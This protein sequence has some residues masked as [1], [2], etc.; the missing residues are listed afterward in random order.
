MP[1]C[2]T[3][4][5]LLVFNRPEK[6]RALIAA[7]SKVRPT[8]L[9][10]AADG[11]RPDVP[12]DQEKCAQTRGLFDTLPWPCTVSRFFR[13]ENLGCGRGPVAGINWF[14]A[15]VEAGIILEDDCIP[16]PAFFSFAK[17]LLDHYRD[18]DQIMHISGT[19]FLP[20]LPV[21]IDTSYYFSRIVHGW[22]W[23]TWRRAWKKMDMDMGDHKLVA[24]QLARHELFS[25]PAHNAFWR[26]LFTHVAHHGHSI[27]DTQWEYTLLR[28]NGL[29]ITPATNLIQ[30]I[31]FDAEATH[32]F[33]SNGLSLPLQ[34]PLRSTLT[35]PISISARRD[36][37][38]IIMKKIF[39]RSTRAHVKA[40]LG[41]WYD[42][43]T[44]F[45]H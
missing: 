18:Q 32:T 25:S 7:L 40:V 3:P 19:S 11:P 42:W 8:H 44:R 13:D 24:R 35:H 39:L 41:S 30:N 1:P 4:I 28:H 36:I 5:L 26:Q 23:A 9:Y 12:G 20:L 21:T 45:T 29:S 22:G 38:E 6:T 10:V 14:F 43:F 34:Q 33:E 31:G 15:Q 2:T 16:H 27:W 17:D 37:D